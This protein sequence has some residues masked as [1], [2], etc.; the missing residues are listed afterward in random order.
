MPLVHAMIRVSGG[1]LPARALALLIGL[2]VGM[3]AGARAQVTDEALAALV[4]GISADSMRASLEV[5]TGERSFHV[6]D[7]LYTEEGGWL[8]DRTVTI[9][10][11]YWATND[12]PADWLRRRLESFGLAAWFHEPIGYPG[13]TNV[14]ARIDGSTEP[15]KQ[16]LVGAHYDAVGDHPGADDNGSGTAAVLEI[17]RLLAG[18]QPD[19]TVLFALWDAEEIGLVGSERY[20]QEAKARGDQIIAAINLDM[21]GWNSGDPGMLVASYDPWGGSWL[22]DRLLQ[23]APALELPLD[24][25]PYAMGRSDHVSFATKGYESVMLI[26][27]YG[28]DFNPYYHSSDD[29]IENI[30]F[31]YMTAITRLAAA[32]VAWSAFDALSLGTAVEDRPVAADAAAGPWPNPASDRLHFDVR[33]PARIEL[34]DVLGRRVLVSSGAEVDV[35][36]LPVGLYVYRVTGQARAVGGMVAVNR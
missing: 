14:L 35:S 31:D 36:A 1:W 16:V 34:F 17:A 26:E 2:S 25:M 21:I 8:Y 12:L 32:G 30:D 10:T 11:R 4:E 23:L 20:A 29:T 27:H 3:P 9:P 33:G 28:N 22:E 24:A 18:M 7:S 19:R 5:L 13:V 15:A 6:G